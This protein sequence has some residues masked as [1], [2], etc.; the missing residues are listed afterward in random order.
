LQGSQF[1]PDTEVWLDS[2]GLSPLYA[3]QVVYISPTELY[4]TFNLRGLNLGVYNVIAQRDADT[5]DTLYQAFTVEMPITGPI[6]RDSPTGGGGGSG[7]SGFSCLVEG[8]DELNPSLEV[9]FDVPPELRFNTT[10][11]MTIK[12]KNVGNMD[13]ELPKGM[14]VSLSGSTIAFDAGVLLDPSKVELELSFSEDNAPLRVLRPGAS[15]KHIIFST[16]IQTL[17]TSDILRYRFYP[18]N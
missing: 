6:N 4:A 2:A 7:S 8:L 13:I 1:R 9:D 5:Q 16:T 10:F 15:D 12:Y 14:F 17:L 18:V 3:S 11:V